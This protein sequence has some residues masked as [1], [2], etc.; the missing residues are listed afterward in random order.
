MAR[1]EV[2]KQLT[3]KGRGAKPSRHRPRRALNNL[4]FLEHV[5]QPVTRAARARSSSS[6]SRAL[7]P[8]P[9]SVVRRSGRSWLPVGHLRSQPRHGIRRPRNHVGPCEV[10]PRSSPSADGNPVLGL[11]PA[12]ESRAVDMR[13][14]PLSKPLPRNHPRNQP[15]RGFLFLSASACQ[16][17]IPVHPGEKNK[18]SCRGVRDSMT[19]GRSNA[20]LGRHWIIQPF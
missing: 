11:R 10:G 20:C 7:H 9:A 18:L 19:A 2:A 16:T 3:C 5:A 12:D 14:H 1:I 17:K 8:K 13:G 15:F 4:T 6:G